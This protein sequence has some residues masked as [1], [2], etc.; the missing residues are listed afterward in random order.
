MSSVASIAMHK[1]FIQHCYA[2]RINLQH[3]KNHRA[4][5]DFRQAQVNAIDNF[6]K[7]MEIANREANGN[8]N[9]RHDFESWLVWNYELNQE[10][11]SLLMNEQMGLD[12]KCIDELM[13]VIGK[14][15]ETN[16]TDFIAALTEYEHAKGTLAR[17]VVRTNQAQYVANYFSSILRKILAFDTIYM[18]EIHRDRLEEELKYIVQRMQELNFS[19]LATNLQREWQT[20]KKS[21][22]D[23]NES[24]AIQKEEINNA[25]ELCTLADK[26]TFLQQM[27]QKIGEIYESIR[28]QLRQIRNN[29]FTL[30][31]AFLNPI[32]SP[33]E[34][35]KNI[36]HVF[37]HP[38]QTAKVAWEWI[39]ENPGKTARLVIGTVGISLTIGAVV[40]VVGTAVCTGTSIFS[41]TA[42]DFIVGVVASGTA[43]TTTTLTAIGGKAARESA[44][45]A[46]NA[47]DSE[48]MLRKHSLE[49][50]DRE[51]EEYR[52][53]ARQAMRNQRKK[54]EIESRQ[55]SYELL[56]SAT[57]NVDSQ[58][59][60][61]TL[62]NDYDRLGDAAQEMQF[63]KEDISRELVAT[64]QEERTINNCLES[65]I[66]KSQQVKEAIKQNQ[67]NIIRTAAKQLVSMLN[68]QD[69][70]DD[71]AKTLDAL[72]NQDYDELENLVNEFS[73]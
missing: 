19:Q 7:M 46:S 73:L 13:I 25:F 8:G 55:T 16:K 40:G 43:L 49:Q 2:F 35:A 29:A 72:K 67:N 14:R 54:D 51:E 56:N 26:R 36:L 47:V 20:F 15:K 22:E 11:S 41:V 18:Y 53:H 4:E 61:S 5:G 17:R 30:Q 58:H 10:H 27:A 28:D 50:L 66:W 57:T 9:L 24:L 32:V 1:E 71:A 64:Y 3:I 6:K 65:I 60:V 21:I 38:L 31:Q 48:I 63:A 69:R 68:E 70:F 39:C 52:K 59:V 37:C 42:T 33:L 12:P 23:I 45:T 62:E 34:S 44:I